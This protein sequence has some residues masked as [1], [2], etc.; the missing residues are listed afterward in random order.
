[1]PGS[2]PPWG[3]GYDYTGLGASDMGINENLLLDHYN[4]E[5][6]VLKNRYFASARRVGDYYFLV[7]SI[8][9]K[10]KPYFEERWP[11]DSVRWKDR[12]PEE[13]FTLFLRFRSSWFWPRFSFTP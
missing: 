6:F 4:G 12:T 13:K 8:V 2:F 1:M 11:E 5:M 10:K 3:N 7:I 9:N